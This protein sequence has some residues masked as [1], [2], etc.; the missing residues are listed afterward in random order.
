MEVKTMIIKKHWCYLQLLLLCYPF[1]LKGQS[2]CLEAPKDFAIEE[3][4]IANENISLLFDSIVTYWNLSPIK[5]TYSYAI[6]VPRITYYKQLV[7]QVWIKQLYDYDVFA[8]SVTDYLSFARTYVPLGVLR[9]NQHVFIVGSEKDYSGRSVD[10]YSQG[11]VDSNF[12][13]SSNQIRFNQD[14]IEKKI[15]SSEYVHQVDTIG[16][17]GCDWEMSIF[18]RYDELV[19]EYI[20]TNNGYVCRKKEVVKE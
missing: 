4:Y 19:I 13:T 6:V 17:K 5:D 7:W 3:V 12:F 18:D 16:G 9:Y 1:F 20:E 15:F 10:K 2:V 8:M 11:V 14:S